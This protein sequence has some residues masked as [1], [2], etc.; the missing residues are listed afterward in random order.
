MHLKESRIRW[1][2]LL[3]LLVISLVSYGAYVGS[4][5]ALRFRAVSLLR[6]YDAERALRV[7]LSLQTLAT[8]TIDDQ[9]LLLRIYRKL[10]DLQNFKRT[11][12]LLDDAGLSQTLLAPRKFSFRLRLGEFPKLRAISVRSC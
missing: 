2:I 11:A 3:R 9:Q 6:Q 12:G 4:V 8:S 1:R 10:G 7:M 5:A